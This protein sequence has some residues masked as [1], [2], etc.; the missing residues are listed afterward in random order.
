M[1]LFTRDDLQTL[2]AEHPS[3][4]VSLFMPAHCG[5]AEADPIRWRKPGCRA[6]PAVG[7]YRERFL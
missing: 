3:P 5:G 4:C 1:D 2:L 6:V 7:G